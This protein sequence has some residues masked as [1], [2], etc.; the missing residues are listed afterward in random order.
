MYNINTLHAK[1]TIIDK[2]LGSINNILRK[3]EFT[4][5]PFHIIN[6]SCEKSFENLLHYF[7][8]HIYSLLQCSKTILLYFSLHSATSASISCNWSFNIP[9]FSSSSWHSCSFPLS[10]WF[11]L[12]LHFLLAS[13]FRSLIL[14]CFSFFNS[15]GARL[16]E[17][18]LGTFVIFSGVCLSGRPTFLFVDVSTFV[19]T[20]RSV[21]LIRGS[22]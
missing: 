21:C 15:S 10:F 9:F 8:G 5:F 1:F 17:P 7:E 6:F 3:H 16:T 12:F 18:A 2:F 13:L 19:A 14:L 22:G 4:L 11:L 20:P